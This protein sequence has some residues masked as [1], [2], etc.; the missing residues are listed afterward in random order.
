MGH[1]LTTQSLTDM[2]VVPVPVLEKILRAIL[3]YLFLIVA[4]KIWGK[5]VMAQLNPFDLVV[6]LILS[7]TVQN[8]IIGNDN[9]FTGGVIGAVALL[10]FNN[11]VVRRLYGHTRLERWLEGRSDLLIEHGQVKP[12][13]LKK[14]GV[15]KHE[16]VMAAHKQGFDSFNDIEKAVLAPGGGLWF[17]RHVPTTD[18]AR[19]DELLARLDRIERLISARTPP[20][21]G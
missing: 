8:A 2:F 4:L 6:L 11:F 18:Q 10:V 19:Q 9:S 16:L 21:A 12:E 3:V 15:S 17:F 1:V 20:A 13:R 5:R 7:N 14:D